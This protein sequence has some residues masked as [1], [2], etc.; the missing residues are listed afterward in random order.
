[1]ARYIEITALDR[2]NWGR[3][4]KKGFELWQS[5]LPHTIRTGDGNK[6]P[7]ITCFLQQSP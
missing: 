2:C 4:K 5:L 6:K 7:L 1:M 3:R